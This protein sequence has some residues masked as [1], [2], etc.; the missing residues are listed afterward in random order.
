MHKTRL[1]GTLMGLLI[2]IAVVHLV[3]TYLKWYWTI[4]WIDRIPHFSA[5]LL[6]GLATLWFVY[7]SGYVKLEKRDQST[8]F[9]L[10]FG[11][12]LVIGLLW[13]IFEITTGVTSTIYVDYYANTTGDLLMDMSGG[14]V[15]YI[16][17]SY[18]GFSKV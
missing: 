15:A 13:E 17:F 12:A 14:V 18:K 10:A 4:P 1:F 2:F 8:L 9:L 6:V 5:G 7:I 16:Y 3:A 11:A